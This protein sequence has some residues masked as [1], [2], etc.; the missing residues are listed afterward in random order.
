MDWEENN[1]VQ[2]RVWKGNDGK[3]YLEVSRIKS[4]NG[5]WDIQVKKANIGKA[6]RRDNTMSESGLNE[7]QAMRKAYRIL[8]KFVNGKA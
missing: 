4:A 3:R 8:Q 2:G 5:L 1:L 7:K 6:L